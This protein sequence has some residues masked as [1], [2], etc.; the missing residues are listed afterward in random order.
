MLT[1]MRTYVRWVDAL[2]YRIGRVA[3][4]LLFAMIGILLW[5]S[6]AAKMRC[7]VIIMSIMQANMS[8]AIIS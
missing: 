7:P 5:S 6:I 1:M 8:M 4:Y 2:N 3:M